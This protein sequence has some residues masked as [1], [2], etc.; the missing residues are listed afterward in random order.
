MKNKISNEKIKSSD[1]KIKLLELSIEEIDYTSDE[2]IKLLELSIEKIDYTSS[3]KIKNLENNASILN[4]KIKKLEDN[5]S[6]LNKKINE[7]YEEKKYK[8]AVFK[9]HEINAIAN[10]VFKFEYRKFFNIDIL[11][12]SV[13]IPNIGTFIRNPPKNGKNY[14]FWSKF[15]KLYPGS[16]NIHFDKIYKQ[17]NKFRMSQEVHPIINDITEEEFTELTNIVLPNINKEVINSYRKW[18]YSF[19][20]IDE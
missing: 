9:L 3:E 6:N 16:D 8:S 17:L 12:S 15:T 13:I 4:K 20:F 11:S 2:K 7:L 19:P 5:G 14:D 1:E 10:S 18:L